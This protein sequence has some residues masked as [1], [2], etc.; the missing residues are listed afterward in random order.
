MS[1]NTME[2][3]IRQTAINLYEDQIDYFK[4]TGENLSLFCREKIDENFETMDKIESQIK[5]YK[6]KLKELNKRKE[7]LQATLKDKK[8]AAPF[9]REARKAIMRNRSFLPGQ[10]AKFKNEFGER[11]TPKQFLERCKI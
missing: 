6:K 11:L 5:D 1:T 8:N 9:F 7:I 10:I 2:R 3:K 4:K